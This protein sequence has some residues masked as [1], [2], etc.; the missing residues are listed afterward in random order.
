MK[1]RAFWVTGAFLIFVLVAF[2][3][4][5]LYASAIISRDNATIS[6][7]ES[8]LSSAENQV[9]SLEN[10]L[11]SAKIQIASTLAQLSSAENQV[12]SLQ[13]QLSSANSQVLSLQSQLSSANSQ[14]SSL[15]Q[16]S[17]RLAE[18]ITPT[19]PTHN[20]SSVDYNVSS[21]YW[22]L[23]WVGRDY[24]LQQ[25]TRQVNTTYYQW[26]TYIAN[27]TDCNDMA[28]DLWDMLRRQ[29]ITSLIA[30]GNMD[31]KGETFGQCNHAWLLIGT[32][33][34]KYFALEPTNGQIYLGNDP[35]WSQY[36][37]CLLYAKP[38]DLRAD[39]GSRW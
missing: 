29:G 35:Q 8:Q 26:H 36:A 34:G 11:S 30:I 24:Q 38:S 4:Y 39:I 21:T 37:E 20:L 18:T 32:G 31:L 33:S 15:K 1:S 10:Q 5:Y 22:N 19:K 28:C 25:T 14:I 3:F 17:A 12:T 6:D 13:S 16:D 7:L 2:I 27:E 23:A 9:T